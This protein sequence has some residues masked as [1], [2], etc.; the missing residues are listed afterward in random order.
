M[1]KLSRSCVET[2]DDVIEGTFTDSRDNLI[3]NDYP[4][5][6]TGLSINVASAR[7]MTTRVNAISSAPF[8]ER[9]VNDGAQRTIHLSHFLCKK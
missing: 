6:I 8:P 7:P 9:A 5:I 3:D 2:S 4:A 1:H